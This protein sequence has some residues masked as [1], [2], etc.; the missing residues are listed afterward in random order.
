MF[1]FGGSS[2]EPAQQQSGSSAF[3]FGAPTKPA[4]G[5]GFNFNVGSTATPSFSATPQ[6][7]GPTGNMFSIGTSSTAPRPRAT[8]RYRKK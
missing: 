1:S 3:Q 7:G 5:G 8:T 6:F 2:A 4:S